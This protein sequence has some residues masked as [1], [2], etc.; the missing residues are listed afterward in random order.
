M[1]PADPGSIMRQ[2]AASRRYRHVCDD[3][4]RRI[5]EAAAA[6]YPNEKQAVKA[7]KRKL[8]QM[9]AS[10]LTPEYHRQADQLLEQ[11][12]ADGFGPDDATPFL[13]LHASTRERLPYYVELYRELAQR[14]GP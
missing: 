7:V 2:V 3:T 4:V 1:T 10:Y 9:Y 14:T 5:S 6:A 13:S 8:H 11:L 12:H